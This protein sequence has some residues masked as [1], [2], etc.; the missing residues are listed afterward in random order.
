MGVSGT[1]VWWLSSYLQGHVRRHAFGR[2]PLSPLMFTVHCFIY[3]KL[4]GVVIRC[5][6]A[7]C[8]DAHLCFSI[9]S[10]SDEAVQAPGA[11]VDGTRINWA[12]SCK[13][14]GFL[15]ERFPCTRVSPITCSGYLGL[16]L[17]WRSLRVVVHLY[18]KCPKWALWLGVPSIIF[19]WYSSCDHSWTKV[20]WLQWSM[21]W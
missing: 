21:Y 13:D 6:G 17:I 8:H 5:S 19:A 1:M 4:Q 2:V 10:E 14:R 20:V 3:M 15:G 7:R 16:H 18:H 9:A 12:V 11:V